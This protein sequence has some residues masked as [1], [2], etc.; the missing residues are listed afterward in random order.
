M[1]AMIDNL[2]KN[3]Y[4]TIRIISLIVLCVILTFLTVRY[5]DNQKTITDL[6]QRNLTMESKLDSVS[7]ELTS[8]LRDGSTANKTLAQNL[9]SKYEKGGVPGVENEMH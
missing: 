6:K 8:S 7:S 2:R 5:F 9:Q 1:S 4:L 3:L